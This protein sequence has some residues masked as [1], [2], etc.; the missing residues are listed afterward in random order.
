MF[1]RASHHAEGEVL[2]SNQA[3]GKLLTP[4]NDTHDIIRVATDVL[5]QIWLAGHRYMK[6][7]VIL[8]DFSTRLCSQLNLFDK[9]R[10]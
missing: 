6:A 4:S 2:Y 1:A 9:Y 10:P 7:G 5:N 3:P 8:G